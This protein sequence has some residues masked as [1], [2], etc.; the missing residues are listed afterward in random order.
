VISRLGSALLLVLSLAVPAAA[1]FAPDDQ[2]VSDLNTDLI[3]PEFDEKGNRLVWQDNVGRLWVASIDPVTGFITPNTGMGQLVD[4]G[5][6]PLAVG[7]TLN[8]P[9]WAYGNDGKTYIVYSKPFGSTGSWQ[10]GTAEDN[11]AGGWT[12]NSG[13]KSGHRWRPAGTLLP[14]STPAREL[15]LWQKDGSQKVLAWRYVNQPWTEMT[16]P[17]ANIGGRWVG[18]MDGFVTTMNIDGVSQVIYVEAATGYYDQLTK[19]RGSKN[20]AYGWY[21]PEFGEYIFMAS[22]GTSAVGIYRYVDRA[23]KR[24]YRIKFPSSKRYIASP[25]PFVAYGRSYIQS[26]VAG[27][28]GQVGNFPNLPIGPSEIWIAGID[29]KKPFF[30]RVDDPNG[31]HHRVDPETFAGTNDVFIY[32]SQKDEGQK[33]ILRRAATGLSSLP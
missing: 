17:G 25:E 23:W 14:V 6:G 1:D 30:R 28:V 11:G 8:G 12:L 19:D 22:L 3:D 4:S 20:Q 27:E 10:L 2:I 26:I 9:E 29:P 5:L 13:L 21:A 32:Y 16:L 31:E 24:I 7:K 33:T 18:G 15:Y